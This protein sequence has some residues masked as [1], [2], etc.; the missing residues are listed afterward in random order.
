M[1]NL[2]SD[3]RLNY[4]KTG[5][6]SSWVFNNL[7]FFWANR[8]F[9]NDLY[10]GLMTTITYWLFWRA[11]TVFALISKVMFDNPVF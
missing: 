1:P 11:N 10:A 7:A 5:A 4:P 6:P 9:G 3:Q 8:A 2:C